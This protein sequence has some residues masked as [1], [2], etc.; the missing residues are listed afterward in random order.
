M[1]KP[2]KNTP[3]PTPKSRELKVEHPAGEPFDRE[4]AMADI[5]VAGVGTNAATAIQFSRATFGEVGITEM[6]ASLRATG[7]EVAG[8]SLQSAER[9]LAAQA[10]SLNAIYGELARRAALNMGEH[11][12]AFDR[13]MRL[14]L[15]AQSQ[16]RTTLET[17]AAIKNPPVV[18]AKQAN[19]SNGPQQV[20]N[21]AARGFATSTRTP[22]H[23]RGESEPEQSRLLEGEQHGGT[24]LD[25]GAA[26]TTAAGNPALE[27]VAA[28]NRTEDSSR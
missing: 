24:H 28:V 3:E 18:F 9:L 14:A 6:V 22:P 5:V 13:Y 25:A 21:G 27:P 16:C 1:T 4:R 2:K 23:A 19:I 8:G 17:L 10:A 20:N 26:G 15:K 12:D 11:P 7:T